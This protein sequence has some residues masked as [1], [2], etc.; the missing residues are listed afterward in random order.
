MAFS[1]L[2]PIDPGT[3]YSQKGDSE[4]RHPNVKIKPRDFSS[5]LIKIKDTVKRVNSKKG[6]RFCAG[7][8]QREKQFRRWQSKEAVS[9]VSIKKEKF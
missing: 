9:C 3:D 2:P 4:R 7:H 6:T 5:M 8:I 1:G